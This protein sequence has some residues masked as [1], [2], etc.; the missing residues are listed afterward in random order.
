MNDI[1]L[2]E[3]PFISFQGE[4]KT[5]GKH[6]LFIRFSNC[7]LNCSICDSKFTWRGKETY[8]LKYDK[9]KEFML[10]VDNVVITGGEPLLQ[11]NLKS[12]IE[13]IT[14][15]DS[16]NYEIE[17]SGDIY[18]LSEI[19]SDYDYMYKFFRRNNVLFNISPKFNVKQIDGK[20][21]DFN[22]VV[23]FINN[24]KNNNINYILK[25]L[26]WDKK[27]IDKI[28]ELVY[29]NNISKSL[30]YLQPLG[31]TDKGIK[32]IINN[33]IQYIIDKG[34]NISIRQHIYLFGNK[35]GV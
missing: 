5:Q 30:V 9:L 11:E 23:N 32:K 4:G 29:S 16:K 33:N 15:F 13:I 10:K 22:N 31:I 20:I 27:S 2:S 21:P 8:I 35:R 28:D 26:F 25:F 1:I 19:Y 3:K 14:Y 7:N 17:T 18:K 6:S 24:L 12:V 34:Y